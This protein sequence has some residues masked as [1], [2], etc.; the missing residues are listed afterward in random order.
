MCFISYFSEIFLQ[1]E[2]TDIKFYVF[3][4][5][6]MTIATVPIVVSAYW[7]LLHFRIFE[8]FFYILVLLQQTSLAN[9]SLLLRSAYGGWV[10]SVRMKKW[11]IPMVEKRWRNINSFC[12]PRNINQ[13]SVSPCLWQKYVSHERNIYLVDQL[14]TNMNSEL[15]E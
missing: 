13:G 2:I 4:V 8:I 7:N 6:Y 9:N 12:H 15:S 10:I 1:N 14:Y 11:N 3:L 5:I